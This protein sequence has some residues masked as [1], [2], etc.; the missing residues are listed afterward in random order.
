MGCCVSSPH[1]QRKYRDADDLDEEIVPLRTF[2][3]YRSGSNL[4]PDDIAG[5]PSTHLEE[6]LI[7]HSDELLYEAEIDHGYSFRGLR[8]SYLCL[9]TP[10]GL[11]YLLSKGLSKLLTIFPCDEAFCWVR[12]NTAP[13]RFFVSTPIELCS[14]TPRS[15]FPGRIVGAGAGTLIKFWRI[16]LIVALL[17][18]LRCGVLLLTISAAPGHCTVA[19]WLVIDVPAMV[20]FGIGC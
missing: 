2:G 14:I 12:N 7:S 19:R 1:G 15:D 8:L 18:F 11:V 4:V 20:P 5:L 16:R 10:W 9:C 13:E 17:V 3:T 6:H